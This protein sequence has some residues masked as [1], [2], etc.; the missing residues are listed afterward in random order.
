[1]AAAGSRS[2]ERGISTHHAEAA[3]NNY[4]SADDNDDNFEK[5][6]SHAGSVLHDGRNQAPPNEAKST[7]DDFDVRI[8]K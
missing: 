3:A 8:R 6:A 2:S 5:R 7:G 1:M 4:A